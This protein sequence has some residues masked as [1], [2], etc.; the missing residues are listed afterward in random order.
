LYIHSFK[1]ISG[2]PVSEMY[3]RKLAYTVSWPL[4]IGM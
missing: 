4:M 3:G 1:S 2:G